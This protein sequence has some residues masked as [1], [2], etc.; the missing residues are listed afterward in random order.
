MLLIVATVTTIKEIRA[1]KSN[2]LNTSLP[3]SSVPNGC[4]MLPS[5]S[6]NGGV[7]HASRSG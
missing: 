4:A 7:F 5:A 1:P 6:Q 2:L 3:R